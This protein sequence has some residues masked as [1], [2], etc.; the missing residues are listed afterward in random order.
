M[1]NLKLKLNA[2]DKD[3]MDFDRFR[4]SEVTELMSSEHTQKHQ[5]RL[6]P[7]CIQAGHRYCVISVNAAVCCEEKKPSRGQRLSLLLLCTATTKM[8]TFLKHLD[9]VSN[10]KMKVLKD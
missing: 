9:I 10:L 7:V 4:D 6:A 8:S 3:R 1:S 5:C 2:L